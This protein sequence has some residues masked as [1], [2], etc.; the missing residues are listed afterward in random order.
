MGALR[1]AGEDMRIDTNAYGYKLNS[2]DQMLATSFVKYK[3][4]LSSLNSDGVS[5]RHLW[6]VLGPFLAHVKLV[7]FWYV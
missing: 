4:R 1:F 6:D 2:S 7:S 3:I 5:S